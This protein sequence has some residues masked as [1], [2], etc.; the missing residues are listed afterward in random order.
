MVAVGL[1]ICVTWH[2]V[3]AVHGFA[4]FINNFYYLRKECALNDA[5]ATTM[6]QAIAVTNINDRSVPTRQQQHYNKRI[7]KLRKKSNALK[8]LQP[9]LLTC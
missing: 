8:Y 2:G 3:S 4:I 1:G 6:W 9:P 7:Y 5:G